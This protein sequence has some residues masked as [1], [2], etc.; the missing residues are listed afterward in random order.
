[1]T[2]QNKKINEERDDRFLAIIGHKFH[3]KLI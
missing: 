2:K 3:A 1:M